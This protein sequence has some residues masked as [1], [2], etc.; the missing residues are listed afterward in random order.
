MDKYLNN[1][2]DNT[3][4]IYGAVTIGDIWRFGI[5][6]RRD[7]TILKDIDAFLIPAALE[8]LFSVFLGI[9]G[10]SDD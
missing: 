2:E 4:F 10:P 3:E 1:W 7:K 9:L 5:L 8:E 6:N